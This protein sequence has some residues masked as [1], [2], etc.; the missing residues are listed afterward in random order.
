MFDGAKYKQGKGAA[1]LHL[2][3][4]HD[5][6][7]PRFAVLTEGRTPEI[8]IAREWQFAPGTIVVFDRGYV[9]YQWYQRL[10]EDG[11]FLVTRLRHDAH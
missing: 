1:K 3:L 10:H 7:L 8:K 9:D 5:G 6:Y 2:V 11:V 4:D